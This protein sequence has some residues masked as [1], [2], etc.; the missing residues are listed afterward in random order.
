MCPRQFF[1]KQIL[2][3]TNKTI[4]HSLTK[5]EEN[6]FLLARENDDLNI[7]RY[8]SEELNVDDHCVDKNGENSL[9]KASKSKKIEI[10]IKYVFAI[11][12]R[13]IRSFKF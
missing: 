3:Q 13:K 12:Y 9:H 11:E 1:F 2:K 6:S 5:K 8:I 10:I 7:L 4:I